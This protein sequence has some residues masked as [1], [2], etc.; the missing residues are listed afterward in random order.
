MRLQRMIAL[1]S[2]LSRR[3]AEEAISRGD[4]TVNGAAVI[5]LGTTVDPL[6]DRIELCGKPLQISARRSYLAYFKPR[7]VLVTKSDPHHRPTIWDSLG[8]LEK[9]AQRRGPAGLRV[10]RPAP[11]LR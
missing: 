4:V 1:S 2:D 6:K 11:A 10:R 7:D 9:D 5:A 8:E 3:A